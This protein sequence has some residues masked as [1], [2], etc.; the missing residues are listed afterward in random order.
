MFSMLPVA[1][2]IK[3]NTSAFLEQRVFSLQRDAA[4]VPTPSGGH[5]RVEVLV[6][7]TDWLP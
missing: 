5:G 4:G 3:H 2:V 7:V 6:D 1:S